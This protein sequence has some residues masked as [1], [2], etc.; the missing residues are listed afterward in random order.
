MSR[1]MK[2]YQRLKGSSRN[3]SFEDLCRLAVYAGFEL[4]RE[5]GSHRIYRHDSFPEKL[6]NFQ[7]VKGEAKPYQVKQLINFIEEE[8]L[9]E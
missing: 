2:L 9:I 1:A 5:S 4:V 8:N 7:S 6:M 3:V